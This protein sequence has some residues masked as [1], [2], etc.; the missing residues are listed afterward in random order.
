MLQELGML[1]ASNP[2]AGIAERLESMGIK[3]LSA[4][5]S[6]RSTR[7]SQSGSISRAGS[8]RSSISARSSLSGSLAA[9]VQTISLQA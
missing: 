8:V 3:P 5:T 9:H 7:S 1:A 4:N 6:P 2:A